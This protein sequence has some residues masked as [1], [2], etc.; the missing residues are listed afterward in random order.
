M[1]P[2]RPRGGDGGRDADATSPASSGDDPP[3]DELEVTADD[4]GVTEGASSVLPVHTHRMHPGF[5]TYEDPPV[6]VATDGPARPL[7]AWSGTERR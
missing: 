1:A 7:Q 3:E 6:A 5:L 2:R 4:P